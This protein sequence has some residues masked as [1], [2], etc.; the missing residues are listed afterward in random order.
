MGRCKSLGSL[1]SFF[2][3]HLNSLGSTSWGYLVTQS[4][5]TLYDP[6]D[7][8]MP[9]FFVHR[10]IH[11]NIGVGCHFFLQRIFP[12]QGW[13]WSLLHLLHWQADSLP[14]SHLG[15]PTRIS[16]LLFSSWIPSECTAGG[17]CG[18]CWHYGLDILCLL[19]CQ[20]T[21]FA[22]IEKLGEE[23]Y[24]VDSRKLHKSR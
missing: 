23:K 4:C 3:I 7:C 14:L 15:S 9:G 20:V 13:Y 21:F 19:K 8:G 1:K 18:G 22:K 12:A 6:M 10:I 5:P 17:G 11:K 16:T 24:F 2:D